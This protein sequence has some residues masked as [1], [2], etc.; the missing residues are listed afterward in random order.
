MQICKIVANTVYGEICKDFER[1]EFR[2]QFATRIPM[3]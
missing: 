3:A 2:N 1:R